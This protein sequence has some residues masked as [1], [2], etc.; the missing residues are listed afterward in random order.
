MT[1]MLLQT[2]LYRPTPR[3][4]LIPRVRLCERL[5][6]GLWTGDTFGRKL[7]LIAAPA[8]FGKTT[9]ILD[10]G[11]WILDVSRPKSKIENLKSAWLSLDEADNDPA[12]FLRYVIA[13]LQSALPEVGREAVAL[14]ESGAPPALE[15]ALTSLINA[16]AAAACPVILTLDD[17]HVIH[18]AG[19]EPLV[20]FLLDHQPPNLHLIIASRSD[21]ALPLA[22]LRARGQLLEVRAR[23]LRFTEAEAAAFFTQT[24]GLTLRSEWVAAL[25]QRTEGWIAGLQL[26]ALSMQGRDDA[27]TFI[28][29]FTGS[30]HF[31]L[32]YLVDE[33]LRRQPEALQRFLLETSILQRMCAPLCDAVTASAASE[34]ALADLQRRNLFVIPLDNEHYWFRYHH[35]F[36][37]FLKSHLKRTR[38]DA[39]PALHRRAA[40]WFQAH[41]Y[42]EEALYH[43]FAIPDY[44]YV[45]RLVVDN[46]R[47]V[48]HT[49]RLDTAVQWL[50]SLPGD[51]LHQ[52]P[53][54]GV[55]YCWTLFIRGDYE[56]IAFYLDD[57]TQAFDRMVAV[58]ELP[59]GHPEYNIILHQVVLLRAIVLRHRGDV[60][61]AIQE[62]EHLLPTV[63]ELRQTLGQVV[64]DMGYT[65]CYSQ[66]GYNYVAANDFER[67]D[68][69]L[70]RVS[71]HARACGNFFS[72]AHATM[73]WARIHLVQGHV[74]RAEEICRRELALA[75]Q[76]EYANY[77]AFCL[78]QLALADVLR[79]KQAWDEAESLLRQGLDTA[80]RSG[81][82][83]YLAQGYLIAARLH[84]AQGKSAQAHEDVRQAEQIAAA[85][86]NRFLDDAIA[87]TRQTLAS[88]AAPAQPLIEPLSERE[89]DVLRLICAG[90][91]NQEIADELFIALDT[92]KRHAN[93]L[94]G[95]LGVSRRAQ[96]IIEARKLG[97]I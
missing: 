40:E 43:A 46:W 48:Y 84:H 52:S 24:M 35:L 9:L 21:P 83:Y 87:Q 44:A 32:E 66:M 58:G 61:G 33:V 8:G 94:Y 69:Y 75:E 18:H 22:R 5:Y 45:S 4:D 10:F 93:N 26:A 23:D 51:L 72:L 59:I 6:A 81:H 13:A 88:H 1:A 25:E 54:L 47:R 96:A 29:D 2:K 11:L 74:E 73:E 70:S 34:E 86:H 68:E 97:L 91:S 42:P 37:E 38:A 27:Q 41:Q 14:L 64:V 67:A 19:I 20:T 85:I 3:P 71:S 39:L 60:A 53:A 62:V 90:K 28:Q 50:E 15:E 12:R 31:V 76:P 78:I 55:A 77:P 63:A 49:G 65:A 56:R 79:V 89:L 17:Y 30:Q 92:V 82:A 36:A 95:K 80:R 7:T 57:I 16:I